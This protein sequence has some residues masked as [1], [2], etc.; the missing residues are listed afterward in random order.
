M[1]RETI[2]PRFVCGG[3]IY[4]IM[5][6]DSGVH[7]EIR[8]FIKFQINYRPVT[9][10]LGKPNQR[11]IYNNNVRTRRIMSD[12]NAH[13]CYKHTKLDGLQG[14]FSTQNRRT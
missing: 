1:S 2:L 8:R 3:S 13:V 5:I 6:I 7:Q 4:S 11:L 9:L 12:L 10:L 14:G